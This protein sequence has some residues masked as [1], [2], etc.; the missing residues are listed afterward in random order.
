[1]QQ[2]VASVEDIDAAVAYGPGLR[3]ALMGPHMTLHLGGGAGGI[4]QFI[5]HIGP[6]FQTWWDD[7]GAPRLDDNGVEMQL[8][9]GVSAEAGSASY[10]ELADERDLLLLEVLKVV[11]NKRVLP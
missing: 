10:E 11:A 5:H 4:K 3:W 6:A 1:V 9:S 7:L 8:I 2:G